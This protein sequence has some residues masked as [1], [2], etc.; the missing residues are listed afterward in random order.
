VAEL[1]SFKIIP[2]TRKGRVLTPARFGCL[3]GIPTLNIT[4][5]CIFRCAYCYARGYSQAPEE[6]EIHLFVNLPDLLKQELA[7]K[8]VLPEW[9]ILNT[10][11]DCF[12]SHPDVLAVTFDVISL[13]ME[14][15]VGVSFL[16]KG[17]IPQRFLDLFGKSPE[18]I[19][20]QIGLVSWSERY[21]KGYEPGT[22]S[23][24]ERMGN[25][26]KLQNLGIS[27]EVRVDPIIPFVTDSEPEMEILLRHL[28]DLDVKKVTLSYLH[29]RP[30]I[31]R[32]LMKDLS[33]LH[34]KLLESCFSGR[35]WREVGSSTMTKLLPA[36]IRESGYER[37]RKIAEGFGI[38]AAVCQCKN[39][40]IA[41]NLCS[42]G[43]AKALLGRKPPAQLPL[44]QC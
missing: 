17:I 41:G 39:P 25:I 23:P 28:K 20:A 18:K 14:H 1:K 44:F 43:R 35:E 40:D 24:E 34:R 12:Q 42:S 38:T 33:P 5:G 6:G 19:V 3:A 16:T 31:E 2:R 10:A 30:A 29:L 8:R 15:K 4:R 37:I 21:W 36:R 7:R 27:P 32:Q 11:S 9:V 22:P 13:L 26:R